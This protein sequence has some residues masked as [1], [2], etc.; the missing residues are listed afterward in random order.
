MLA[1]RC[2]PVRSVVPGTVHRRKRPEMGLRELLTGDFL[3]SDN[4]TSFLI[5]FLGLALAVYI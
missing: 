3:L 1:A 4:R 2:F 5:H